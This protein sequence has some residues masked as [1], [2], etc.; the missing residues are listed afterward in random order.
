MASEKEVKIPAAPA[1][2]PAG[3]HKKWAATYLTAFQQVKADDENA[4]DGDCHQAARREA[5]RMLRVEA[6]TSHKEA[7]ALPDWHCHLR[8]EVDGVLKVV[9]ID[10]KKY[11]FDVPSK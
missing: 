7:M 6:P 2:L 5:N 4:N 9:T 3:L 8:E 11:R 10:G 1:E